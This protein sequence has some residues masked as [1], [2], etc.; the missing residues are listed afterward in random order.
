[1]KNYT[2]WLI[3]QINECKKG[4]QSLRDSGMQSESAALCSDAMAYAYREAL[5]HYQTSHTKQKLAAIV[6]IPESQIGLYSEREGCFIP[7]N[8]SALFLTIERGVIIDIGYEFQRWKEQG[9]EIVEYDSME[10][11]LE[12]GYQLKV[13]SNWIGEKGDIVNN[14]LIDTFNKMKA[15][16]EE[17]ESLRE[18]VKEQEFIILGMEEGAEEWKLKCS[19]LEYKL[20]TVLKESMSEQI[21]YE[22]ILTIKH[23]LGAFKNVEKTIE[24]QKYYEMGEYQL[25]KHFNIMDV[26]R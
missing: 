12:K 20:Q 11:L 13:K 22:L 4:A 3:G 10:N 18:R 2:E 16:R 6:G 24:Q 19:D 17:L 8:D 23:L 7:I 14:Q 5:T 26:L 1:M 15:E 9:G 25:S 21:R